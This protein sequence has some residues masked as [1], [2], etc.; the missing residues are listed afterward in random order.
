V[1]HPIIVP[2]GAEVL[3]GSTRLKAGTAQKMVL[4]MIS[5]AVMIRLGRVKGNRMV[6]MQLTN[7]KLI[8]RGTKMIVEAKGCPE[9]EAREQLLKFGSVRAV[10]DAK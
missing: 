3:S 6:D 9:T 10:L 7:E 1:E 4:N 2:V 5:T 8:R